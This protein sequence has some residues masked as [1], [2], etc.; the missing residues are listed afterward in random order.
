MPY[1]GLG[2]DNFY[3]KHIVIEANEWR[4]AQNKG[5]EF[6]SHLGVRINLGIVFMWPF[7]YLMGKN[8]ILLMID[9]VSKWF[10][11]IATLKNV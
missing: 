4:I 2:Y 1:F 9:Y 10:E 5:I 7:H 6:E 8:N 11:A 3:V